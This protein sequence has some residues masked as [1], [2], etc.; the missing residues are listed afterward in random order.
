MDQNDHK[1]VSS[2]F[3][4]RD[5]ERIREAAKRDGLSVAAFVRMAALREVRQREQVAA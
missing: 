5:L 2:R 1:A 3:E 4:E